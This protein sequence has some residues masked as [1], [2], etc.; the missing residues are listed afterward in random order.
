M[1]QAELYS[2]IKSYYPKWIT[3]IK[4]FDA[5]F[6]AQSKMLEKCE[7]ALQQTIDDCTIS[8]CSENRLKEMLNFFK[9]N[10]NL[11]TNNETARLLVKSCFSKKKIDENEIKEIVYKFLHVDCSVFIKNLE[12]SIN[13]ITD[14]VD[15]SNLK[16]CIQE[17]QNK[18]NCGILVFVN[19]TAIISSNIYVGAS[20]TEYR[21]EYIE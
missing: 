14:N 17:I 9:I 20:M 6:F 13:I 21:K 4:E 18:V 2:E 11:I 7:I 10:S 12:L 19:T 3:E 8:Q 5:I 16:L 1:S 15:T